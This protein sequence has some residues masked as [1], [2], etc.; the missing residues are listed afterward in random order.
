MVRLKDLFLETES[1]KYKTW[2]KTGKK[3][4]TIVMLTN[5]LTDGYDFEVNCCKLMFQ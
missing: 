3:K 4:N 2:E 5:C 1:I